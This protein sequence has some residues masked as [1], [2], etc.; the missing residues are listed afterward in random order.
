MPEWLQVMLSSATVTAAALLVVQHYLVARITHRFDLKIEALKPVTAEE[1]LR[2]ESFVSAKR[3][4]FYEAVAV[5]CAYLQAVEWSGPQVPPDRLPVGALPSESEVNIVLAKL[6]MFAGDA[7]I[8]DGFLAC[9]QGAS[10]VRL[11]EFVALLRKDLGYGVMPL[12]YKYHMRRNPS[13]SRQAL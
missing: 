13:V 2:R 4:A 12:D 9:F 1:F 6:A 8:H 11:G 5:V 7:S 3:S 10:P